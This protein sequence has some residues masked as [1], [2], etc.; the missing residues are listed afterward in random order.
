MGG[1]IFPILKWWGEKKSYKIDKLKRAWLCFSTTLFTDEAADKIGP[2]D[3]RLS[4]PIL[5]CALHEIVLSVCL[6]A[7]IPVPKIMPGTQQE[8]KYLVNE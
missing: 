8:L 1:Q 6:T 7:I 4:T 3:Y 5:Q 2:R